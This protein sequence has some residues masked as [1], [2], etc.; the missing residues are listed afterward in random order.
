MRYAPDTLLSHKFFE[1]NTPVFFRFYRKNMT[2][3]GALP[4]RAHLALARLESEGKLTAV[5]TQN[6]DGLHQ[7][8]GS[9]NVLELHGSIHRN[10]CVSC[11]KFHDLTFIR[12]KRGVPLCE[13]GGVVK[14]DV[15][16]YG[17]PLDENVMSAA[18]AAVAGADMLIVGGT[19]LMVH[20][21]AG[22]LDHYRGQK[23]V[24]INKTAISH[25]TQA[26][27]FFHGLIGDVLGDDE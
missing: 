5:V 24:L 11:G 27:H 10:Y 7:A 16:L 25:N 15:V 14:P 12:A 6:I 2:A 26:N 19:S 23:L 18:I 8:A 4:N 21:A 22:V 9:K 20:P 13:C 1:S 3:E 17:E